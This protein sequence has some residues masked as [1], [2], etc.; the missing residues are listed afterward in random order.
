MTQSSASTSPAPVQV[1]PV[2]PAPTPAA[3]V[4]PPAAVPTTAMTPSIVVQMPEPDSKDAFLSF[5]QAFAWPIVVI[6]LALIFRQQIA[7]KIDSLSKLKGPLEAEWTKEVE[8]TADEA[9]V[10]V[11]ESTTANA[12]IVEAHDTVA[13]TG[14]TAPPISQSPRISNERAYGSTFEQLKNADPSAAVVFMW[15]VVETRLGLLADALGIGYNRANLA[16]LLQHLVNTGRLRSGVADVIND[17]RK[18][19]NQAVHLRHLS[20]TDA[21]AF[22]RSASLVLTALDGE[23]D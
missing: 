11:A 21:E 8:E 18:L 2:Q 22:Y 7:A 23:I 10:A 1:T 3:T 15:G 9:A 19:R 13:A 6:V 4:G 5:G 14:S 12:V 17:L 20:V 16:A